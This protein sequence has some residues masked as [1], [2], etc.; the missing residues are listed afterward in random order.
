MTD[1]S[2]IIDELD[3]RHADAR[4]AFEKKKLAAYTSIFTPSLAYHQRDGQT[5]GRDQLMRD[6]RAQF[7][8]LSIVRSSFV[9]EQI[10][11]ENDRATEHLIQTATATAT[12]FFFVHR[13]WAISRKARY[14]WCK[15]EVGW[16]IEK[17]FVL[18]E[19]VSS[20]GFHVGVRPEREGWTQ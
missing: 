6:V 12:A 2:T 8:R 9:R 17:V 20:L 18:E 7:R 1:T 11:I 5:I 13:T 15:T 14:V 16:Q 4:R 19:D 10:D 3:A